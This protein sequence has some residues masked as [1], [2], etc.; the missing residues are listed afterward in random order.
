MLRNRFAALIHVQPSPKTLAETSA[1]FKHLKTFGRVTTFIKDP[2]PLNAQ[3]QANPSRYYVEIA[4]EI[5]SL[6]SGKKF[7]VSVHHNLPN[8]RDEDPLNLRGLQDR[9]RWLEPVQ[10]DC[11]VLQIQ[12]DEQ[13][14]IRKLLKDQNPYRENFTVSKADCLP[15]V[16]RDI[17]APP[18]IIKGMGRLQSAL[19]KSVSTSKI[20]KKSAVQEQSAKQVDLEDGGESRN[21]PVGSGKNAVVRYVTHDQSDKEKALPVRRIQGKV[22]YSN[23]R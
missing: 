20:G 2:S 14:T 12:E 3:T 21:A 9:K 10:F 8:P 18:R 15:Q 19:S 11:T 23:G 1:I 4:N 22:K 16:L 17:N 5:P 6:F 13:A 7:D